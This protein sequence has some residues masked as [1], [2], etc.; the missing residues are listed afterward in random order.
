MVGYIYNNILNMVDSARVAYT[1]FLEQFPDAELAT[2][3]QYELN[4]LGKKP[5]ELLPSEPGTDIQG[6]EKKGH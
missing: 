4:T 3:A 2:S 6:A 1:R 5:E